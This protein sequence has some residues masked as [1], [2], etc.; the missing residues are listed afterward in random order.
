V[1]DGIDTIEVY[2]LGIAHIA[3]DD[4]QLR[5]RWQEIAEPLSIYSH[6]IMARSQQ[7][8]DQNSS[9]VTACTRYQDFHKKILNQLA[10]ESCQP[11]SIA[12]G[13]TQT[14]HISAR[15]STKAL[16][17]NE[18]HLGDRVGGWFTIAFNVQINYA[19]I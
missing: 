5:V 12:A 3:F 11:L 6:D 7:L 15:S 8:G 18:N 2:A 13:Q 4:R 14:A 10:I 9:L 19:R 17:S 1:Y 16:A